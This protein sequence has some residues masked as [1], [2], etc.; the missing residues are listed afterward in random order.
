MA[1]IIFD[2]HLDLA[3]LAVNKRNMYERDLAR[4]YE[5]WPPASVTLPSLVAGNVRFALGTI[6]TERDGEDA[7]CKSMKLFEPF[8]IACEIGRASCRERV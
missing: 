1:P 7:F 5:P 3:A 8:E 2:A 4:V 6:F